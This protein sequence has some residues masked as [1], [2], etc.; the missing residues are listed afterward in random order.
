MKNNER[1]EAAQVKSVLAYTAWYKDLVK[2][3]L[4]GCQ[5]ILILWKYLN[6]DWEE[7]KKLTSFFVSTWIRSERLEAVFRTCGYWN[8]KLKRQFIRLIIWRLGM[9]LTS[10]YL[11][12]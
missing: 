11:M 6:E 8:Q 2:Y 4:A 1:N 9:N 5:Q 7:F 3:Y 10:D 12:W